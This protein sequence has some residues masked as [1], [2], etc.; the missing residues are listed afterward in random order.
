MGY[1][2]MF[3]DCLRQLRILQCLRG[4]GLVAGAEI[5][6]YGWYVTAGAGS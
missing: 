3:L 6:M 5:G 1:M 4:S 2:L